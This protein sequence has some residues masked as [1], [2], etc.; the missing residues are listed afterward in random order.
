MGE[1]VPIPDALIPADAKVE[2]EAKIAAGYFTDGSV[3]SE[4][5]LAQV[6]GRDLE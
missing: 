6:K 2:M 5:D 3:P 4:A 1:R